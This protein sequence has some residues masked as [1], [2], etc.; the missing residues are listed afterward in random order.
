MFHEI[1]IDGG[2]SPRRR[3][4]S[5]AQRRTVLRLAAYPHAMLHTSNATYQH[6]LAGHGVDAGRLPLFGSIP[7]AER[8]TTAWLASLLADAGCD[9]LS[10]IAARRAG[11]WL[12]ALFGR[13][14]LCAAAA[15]ARPIASRRRRGSS[16]SL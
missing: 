1:W 4:V 9:A 5:A 11:W 8:A 16:A 2:A 12:F 3:L 14:I 13:C 15:V 6:A 10:G 7:V